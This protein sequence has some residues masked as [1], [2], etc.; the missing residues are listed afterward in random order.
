M[1]HFLFVLILICP[2]TLRAQ[3]PMTLRGC[4]ER[5]QQRNIKIRQ[6]VLSQ[7]QQKITLDNAKAQHLPEIGGSIGE[8]M[9]FGRGLTAN[10]TY[11]ARNTSSSS[12]SISASMPLYTG[13]RLTHQHRRSQLQLQAAIADV[14]RLR[15]DI[16][17]QVTQA[18]FQVLYQADLVDQAKENLRLS[19]AEEHHIRTK[20]KAGTLSPIEEAQ[21]VSRVAQDRLAVVQAENSH[22]LALLDLSQLLEFS[23]PDSLSIVRPSFGPPPPIAANPEEIYALSLTER[24]AIRA[25]TLRTRAAQEDITIARSGHLPTLSLSAGMGTNYYHT[26]GVSNETFW[27]QL[28]NN[29]SQ[30][31]GLSLQIPIYDHRTTRNNINSARLAMLNRHLDEEETAKNLYKEIQ[32]AYYNAVASRQKWIAAQSADT[33]ALSALTLTRAKYEAGRANAEEYDRARSKHINAVTDRITAYYD[34]LF[35]QEILNFYA[36]RENEVAPKH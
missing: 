12:L 20:I 33:A 36:G 27:R 16:G 29:F 9:S 32:N 14:E 6:S 13:G 7:S 5:A 18:F 8:N 19:K 3:P 24:P 31:I 21:A 1:K 26:S 34:T 15:E 23:T 28:R 17:L 30:S 22:K 4:I 10:N 2:F 35:R 25:A 11:E